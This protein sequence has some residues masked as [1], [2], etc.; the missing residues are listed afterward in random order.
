MRKLAENHRERAIDLLC[1]RL[2]FERA[3]VQLYDRVIEAMRA[4]AGDGD[5]LATVDVLQRNRAQEAEHAAW[6]ESQIRALGGDATIETDLARLATRES[7]G[8]V[9]VVEND[10]ADLTHLLHALLAAEAVDG[11]GWDLLLHLADDA[12][13]SEARRE[14]KRRYHEEQGHL[15][16]VRDAMERMALRSLLGPRGLESR[17]D[18]LAASIP[19]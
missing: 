19:P 6:L 14:F 9:E 5:V 13:D 11:A 12:G 2:V 7:R 4:G 16:V 17:A 10:A 8:I 3:G 1:E 15:T 18:D